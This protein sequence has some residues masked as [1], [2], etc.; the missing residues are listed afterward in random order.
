MSSAVGTRRSL[1]H[2]VLSQSEVIELGLDGS[3]DDLPPLATRLIPSCARTVN[4]FCL[5]YFLCFWTAVAVVVR[6]VAVCSPE[7]LLPGPADFIFISVCTGLLVGSEFGVYCY[8]KGENVLPDSGGSVGG[9]F[10]PSAACVLAHFAL[11]ATTRMCTFMELL[12][13]LHALV[14]PTP[15]IICAAFTVSLTRGAVPLLLQLRS[16]IGYHC[17]DSFDPLQ[18][19]TCIPVASIEA[20]ISR[21]GRNSM[22]AFVSVIKLAWGMARATRYGVIHLAGLVGVTVVRR[23]ASSSPGRRVDLSCCVSGNDGSICPTADECDGG[24]AAGLENASDEIRPISRDGT[25]YPVHKEPL[26]RPA[27]RHDGTVEPACDGIEGRAAVLT[28]TTY[29]ASSSDASTRLDWPEQLPEECD[30]GTP[31]GASSVQREGTRTGEGSVASMRLT[32]PGSLGPPADFE[33]ANRDMR[34]FVPPRQALEL[35]NCLLFL[36]VP[37]LAL[38]VKSNFLPL[39]QLEAHEFLTSMV[40]LVRLY[41]GDCC[42]LLYLIFGLCTFGANVLFVLLLVFLLLKLKSSCFATILAHIAAVFGLW[43]VE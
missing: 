19:S 8:V 9:Y 4:A 5:C 34:P 20:C 43:D 32:T 41:S 37:A 16:L 18:C 40:S 26:I 15:M 23:T 33:A 12:F 42:M 24:M 39:E 22:A 38:H 27:A 31:G 30:G 25:S 7:T 36:D 21:C 13:L 35:T 2:D 1:L 10:A 6:H 14:L 29:R 28:S 17:R 11:S 3:I